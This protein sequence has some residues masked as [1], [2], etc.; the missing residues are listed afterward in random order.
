VSVT[1]YRASRSVAQAASTQQTNGAYMSVSA[2]LPARHPAFEKH[3][4]VK[5]LAELW[6]L[7]QNTIIKLF[8]EEPG[9]IR[10]ERFGGKRK[11][12]TYSIPQGVALRVHER[13]S[14]QALK[15]HRSTLNPL[16]V[17]RLRDLHTGVT[18]KP[19]NIVKLKPS[20]QLADCKRVA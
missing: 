18:K 16:R 11:Y 1:A 14:H 3:F 10:V 20:K 9:V 12:T 7:C 8:A 6:N 19:R 15:P 4:R 13:L 5:A 17:V 2:T